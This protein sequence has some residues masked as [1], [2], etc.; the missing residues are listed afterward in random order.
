MKRKSLLF[1]LLLA[2]FMPW[3]ANAQETLTVYGD[4][5]QTTNAYVPMYG[6]YFDDFTKSEFVIP[7]EKLENMTG[8]TITSMKFYISS[9][10]T[11]GNGWGNTHQVVFLKEVESATLSAWSG[12]DGATTVFDGMFTVPASNDTE[13]EIE[14]TENSYTYQGGNLLV[15]IYN[16]V[17][18][19]YRTV[20]WYGQTVDGASG[21]A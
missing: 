15:G 1:A 20:N 10:S 16:T 2:L 21:G 3:V 18:G 19:S 12:M 7:A 8:G 5:T 13:F 9:V 4:G 6:G 14:F 17:D 11:Y